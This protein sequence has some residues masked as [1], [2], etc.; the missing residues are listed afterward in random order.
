[1]K[2][3]LFFLLGCPQLGVKAA[4]RPPSQPPRILFLLNDHVEGLPPLPRE[5]SGFF[6]S[7]VHSEL[8]DDSASVSMWRDVKDTG[9]L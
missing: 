7:E 6:V 1:M 9:A 4:G 2:A 3:P 5:K 8:S